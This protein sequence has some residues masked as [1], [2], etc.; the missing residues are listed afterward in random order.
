LTGLA[1]DTS[2]ALYG[3]TIGNPVF[4]P[5]AGTP[6]LVQLDPVAGTSILSFPIRLGGDPLE[7]NDLAS[8]PITGALYGVGL[9]PTDAVSSLYTIDKSDGN[10]T[11]L[12]VT[13][14]IGVTIAFAPDGTLYMTSATFNMGTQVGSFLHTVDPMT[15]LPLSIIPIAPLPS[16]NLV[17]IGGLAVSP[18]DGTLFASGR[19]ANVSQRGDIYALTPDGSVTLI[20]STGIGEVGDLAYQPIPEPATL[21]LLTTGLAGLG[22]SRKRLRRSTAPGRRS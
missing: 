8:D 22:A 18:S 14:V 9:N 2:G 20:G 13:G 12:G 21:L 7:I 10:A 19:E 17:H 5:A 11:L 16:G 3:S 4:D 1:F 6:M 15:G